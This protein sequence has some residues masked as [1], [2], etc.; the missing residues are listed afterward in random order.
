MRTL[1]RDDP[2]V[3][4][5][6]ERESQVR[7]LFP[8]GPGLP[9]PS[10]ADTAHAPPRFTDAQVNRLIKSKDAL[11]APGPS[12]Q[13]Y[14]ALKA[15]RKRSPAWVTALRII[16]QAIADGWFIG[17]VAEEPIAACSLTLL[18]KP[19]GT[20]PRPIGIGEVIVNL[21]RSV[22]ASALLR[23]LAHRFPDDFGL[24]TSCGTE[25]AVARIRDVL[26]TNSR[27]IAILLD[28]SNAFG[29]VLR[30]A[31]LEG[32]RRYCPAAIP[33][34][35][36]VYNSDGQAYFPLAN[37]EYRTL[38]ITRGVRQGDSLGPL[39]FM[40]GVLPVLEE[41]RTRHPGI[42]LVSYLDDT[43][44]VGTAVDALDA[45]R[46]LR[47]RLAGI[48]LTLNPSKCRVLA[49]GGMDTE[50][51]NAF[52]AEGL[53]T[54]VDSAELL[55]TF[56]GTPAATHAFL[57][58]RVT[59]YRARLL[60]VEACATRGVRR[61]RL[62]KVLKHCAMT[63]VLHLFRSLEA[64]RTSEFADSVR[65]ASLDS[66]YE[67]AGRPRPVDS[68]LP[69]ARAF[70]PLSLGGLGLPDVRITRFSA[71]LASTRQTATCVD[72]GLDDADPDAVCAWLHNRS[73]FSAALDGL[74]IL[75]AGPSGDVSAAREALAHILAETS[76][77]VQHK[78][79]EYVASALAD[80][81]LANEAEP[82]MEAL[83]RSARAPESW[84]PFEFRSHYESELKDDAFLPMLLL[85][86]G[87][88]EHP[89]RTVCELSTRPR[90]RHLRTTSTVR[91]SATHT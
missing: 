54:L 73:G 53:T 74:A 82:L 84:C 61:Q 63:S 91:R 24:A 36:S 51:R 4:D 6:E 78:L 11:S 2:Y 21:G 10:F 20:K 77:G 67:L 85:R 12:G 13:G 65:S 47:T 14:K 25:A 49:P 17:T 70:A 5:S 48:G 42:A 1:L 89:G 15:L 19:T 88:P 58:D 62:F 52:H 83:D 23:E 27:H 79:A 29:S 81:A 66:L 28:V 35:R 90:V 7:T 55:G 8:P 39:L 80:R 31:I 45:F 18:R 33:L 71:F 76:K 30:S 43:V 86:L 60:A 72:P 46:D 9:A 38:S 64:S 22:A 26:G 57:A 40:L 75:A 56:I 37:G 32:A 50:L 59:E 34:L 87:Y 16:T 41:V 44:P 3:V 68:S 69:D